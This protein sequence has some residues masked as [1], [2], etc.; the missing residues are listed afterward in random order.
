MDSLEY[1]DRLLVL[2]KGGGEIADPLITKRE[3]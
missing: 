3:T 2:E 1:S